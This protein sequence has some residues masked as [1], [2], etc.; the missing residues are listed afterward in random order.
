MN[1]WLGILTPTEKPLL[2]LS[3]AFRFIDPT[4]ANLAPKSRRGQA[5]IAML[6]VAPGGRRSRIWLRERLWSTRSD[7]QAAPSLRQALSDI[8]RQL[9]TRWSAILGSDRHDIW[10]E[11]GQLNIR[12]DNKAEFLEGFDVG[13]VGFTNWLRE[14]RSTPDPSTLIA[15]SAAHLTVDTPVGRSGPAEGPARLPA[16]PSLAILPVRVAHFNARD[17]TIA[18][19]IIDRIISSLSEY[20][21]VTIADYRDSGDKVKANTPLFLSLRCTISNIGDDDHLAFA[22]TE[23]ES[24]TVYFTQQ[25]TV[26]SNDADAINKYHAFIDVIVNKVID[27]FSRSETFATESK[28]A[29]ALIASAAHKMFYLGRDDL[30]VAED[31][32]RQALAICPQPTGWAWLAFLQTFR[33]GQ[34]HAGLRSELVEEIDSIID[35]VLTA[36]PTNALCLTL[37]AHV[38]SYLFRDFEQADMLFKRA[39]S[40][41]P[42]RPMTWALRSNLHAYTG[43]FDASLASA[44][45]SQAL[46]QFSPISFYFESASCINAAISGDVPRAVTLGRKLLQIRPNYIAPQ[47]FVLAMYGGLGRQQESKGLLAHLQKEDPDFSIEQIR[48]TEHPILMSAARD[49]FLGGLSKAG[50]QRNPAN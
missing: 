4:N 29:G 6:A 48:S 1:D 2:Q 31:H 30:A 3:G 38:K 34:S 27:F 40:I 24:S 12:Y 10:L 39:L 11:T 46:G 37:I 36:A 47:R 15:R 44:R 13:D 9:G 8:R 17:T 45:H 16:R 5:I 7:E 49:W 18:D 20:D 14:F 35:R 33:I 50:T 25:F 28:T 42:G 22:I 26:K 32:L 41:H 19:G 43:D 21:I 23:V